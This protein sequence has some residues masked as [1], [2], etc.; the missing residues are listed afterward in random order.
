MRSGSWQ[1]KQRQCEVCVTSGGS[2]GSDSPYESSELQS[3]FESA[4]KRSNF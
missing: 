1:L 4:S 3:I 2:G